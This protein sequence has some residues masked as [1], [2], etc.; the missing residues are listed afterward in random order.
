MHEGNLRR[1][2][3]AV[4]HALAEER[5]AQAHAVETADERRTVIDLD[6]VAMPAFV[7][8][9]IDRADA[10]IDP[11]A[12]AARHRRRT[13][14]DHGVE[15]D[16]AHHAERGPAHRALEARR[17]MEAIERQHAAAL[18]L[19]PVEGRVLGAL[20]HRKDAARIGLEQNFRRDLDE[21]LAVGHD[22]TRAKLRA[23]P[24][25]GNARANGCDIR[26][27]GCSV[28]APARETAA[29]S[30]RCHPRPIRRARA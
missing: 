22:D 23:R 27:R 20:R 9:S 3:Y 28:R 29:A 26:R 4:E 2:A 15:V 12:P 25:P 10:G 1:I 11:G 8:L 7:E 21:C 30:S 14:I 16:V 18:R 19:D 17:N 24:R 5:A 13:G 6:G